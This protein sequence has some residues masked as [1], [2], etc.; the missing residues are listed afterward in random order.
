MFVKILRV[1]ASPFLTWF[2]VDKEQDLEG[3]S[4]FLSLAIPHLQPLL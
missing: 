4:G 2:L 3:P 1:H